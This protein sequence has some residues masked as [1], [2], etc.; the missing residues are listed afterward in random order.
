MW[1]RIVF[2]IIS[3]SI[4]VSSSSID[5]IFLDLIHQNISDYTSL[6][7][8]YRNILQ[9]VRHHRVIDTV[10]S[11]INLS[12]IRLNDYNEEYLKNSVRFRRMIS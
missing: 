9:D 1:Y 8:F 5:S 3:S 11:P 10:S 2:S 4:I 7:N 12:K 6:N